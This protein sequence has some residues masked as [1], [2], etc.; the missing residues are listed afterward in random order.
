MYIVNHYPNLGTTEV[1]EVQNPD[2]L[3]L[4]INSNTLDV[5]ENNPF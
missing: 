4:F 1:V 5:W 2:N 3:E